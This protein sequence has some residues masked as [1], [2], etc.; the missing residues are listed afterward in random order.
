MK[1]GNFKDKRPSLT[2]TESTVLGIS[3]KA[4]DNHFITISS[5]FVIKIQI[6][7]KILKNDTMFHILLNFFNNFRTW[8]VSV[9]KILF[10]NNLYLYCSNNFFRII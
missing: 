1:S 5:K 6:L 9:S 3:K 10:P 4:P 8:F 2:S 7:K